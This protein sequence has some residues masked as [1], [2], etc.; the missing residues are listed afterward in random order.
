MTSISPYK[1]ITNIK[2]GG[3]GEAVAGALRMERDIVI[4]H[5]AVNGVP[6]S[7]KPQDL[8][9]LFGIDCP[10]IVAAVKDVITK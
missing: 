5:L 8:L 1:S 6:R 3:I 9:A 7:G 10:S 4:K 2:S